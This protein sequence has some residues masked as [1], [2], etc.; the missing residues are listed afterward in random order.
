VIDIARGV[1]GIVD[2][3]DLSWVRFDRNRS[4]I[5]QGGPRRLGDTQEELYALW[6]R[7]GRPDRERFG[8][9]VT[10]E[11]TQFAW[12][13]HPASEHRWALPTWP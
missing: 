3:S 1:W 6:C 5:T 12:L 8:V 2:L 4:R 11:R 10:P 13:D 9:T 7:L